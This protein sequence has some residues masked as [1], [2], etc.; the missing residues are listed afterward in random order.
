MIVHFALVDSL[1]GLGDEFDAPHV[2]PVP[3]RRV[4]ERELGAL[5]GAR[6]VGVFV[7]FRQRNVLVDGAGA[8]DVVLVGPDLVGPGPFVEVG[9]GGEVVEAAVPDEGGVGEGEGSQEDGEEG[10]CLHC[11]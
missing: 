3:V 7:G 2:L 6:V 11:G 10:C 5:A 4:V 8:V 1:L 9:G